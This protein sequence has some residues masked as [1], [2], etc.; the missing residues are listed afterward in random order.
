MEPPQLDEISSPVSKGRELDLPM[1]SESIEIDA[2]SHISLDDISAKFSNID[3]QSVD[4]GIAAECDYDI[5]PTPLYQAIESKLWQKAMKIITEDVETNSAKSGADQAKIWVVRK[6]RDGKLRWRMMPLHSAII[7]KAPFGII[8]AILQVAPHTAQCKDDQGMLPIHLAFRYDASDEVIDELLTAYPTGIE[9]KDRK[10]RVPLLCGVSR[11]NANRWRLL[12]TYTTLAVACERNRI[13]GA[14]KDELEKELELERKLH[15]EGVKLVREQHEKLIQEKDDA[16]KSITDEIS[17]VKLTPVTQVAD[18]DNVTQKE[19]SLQFQLAEVQKEKKD[20]EDQVL[21]KSNMEGDTNTLSADLLVKYHGLCSSEKILAEQL[22]SFQAEHQ[23]VDSPKQ[24]EEVDALEGLSV[25]ER[26][27]FIR[28]SL[29]DTVKKLREEVAAKA[30]IQHM[31]E[32]TI[33]KQLSLTQELMHSKRDAEESEKQCKELRNV[34][35]NSERSVNDFAK[36]KLYY[37]TRITELSD[38]LRKTTRQLSS[39]MDISVKK[40]TDVEAAFAVRERMLIAIARQESD[41]IKAATSKDQVGEIAR[42]LKAEVDAIL[43][44]SPLF[45]VPGLPENASEATEGEKA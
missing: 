33:D 2:Q 4:P 7:F 23:G 29:D 22:R 27:A 14:A 16:I 28:T 31:L 20:F 45:G 19:Q 34:A 30:H 35:E 3:S 25:L 36:T 40:K 41:M 5:N 8:E 12:T 32:D 13:S 24:T 44:K 38:A 17:K 39:V 26:I 18:P 1:P 6:E 10:G 42:E 15:Q 21:S 11:G 9:V 37:E 43:H